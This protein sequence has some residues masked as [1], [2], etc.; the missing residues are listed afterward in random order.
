MNFELDLWHCLPDVYTK[1]QMDIL[2]QVEKSPEI[3]EKS[4]THKNNPQ[5]SKIRFFAAHG[6]CVEKYTA[7]RLC[8]KF[9]DLSWFIRPWVWPTFG[10]KLDQGDPITMKLTLHMS[11]H[12]LILYTKF[13]LDILKT[14]W[15]KPEKLRRTNGRTN[16]TVFYG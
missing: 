1:L 13:Q 4:K 2:Q 8:T 11:C 3:F 6:T 15:K 5:I 10:C 9:T 16:K 14:Y 12:I 7:G